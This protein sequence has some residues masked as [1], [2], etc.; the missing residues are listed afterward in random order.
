MIID[1]HCHAGKGDGLSGPWDTDAPLDNYLQW[2]RQSGINKS[3]IF[4][5]FH[6]NYAIANA[7]VAKIVHSNTERFYGFAFVHSQRD[8]GRIFEM[9]K[10]AVEDYGFKG[11][12]L[13]RADATIS[14]EVCE[15]AQMFGLPILYDPMG[16][17]AGM[18]SAV[19][20]YPQVNFIIPHLSSFADDW[21][22]QKGCI[23]LLERYPNAYADTS[24]VRR[25]D[26]LQEAIKRAGAKKFLFGSDGPWLHPG[27]ELSKI[28]A[29]NLSIKAR[30][31]ILSENL[32]NLMPKERAKPKSC[33]CKTCLNYEIDLTPNVQILSRTGKSNIFTQRSN[34]PKKKIPKPYLDH[35]IS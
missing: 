35:E 16:D 19:S 2:C 20:E 27:V 28:Y 31:M 9:V 29:L 10:T 7:E 23:T 18:E 17:I 11:I 15:V 34:V 13:H 30:R 22:A 25:F 33:S 26:V 14:R 4:A 21:K 5:A 12:K 8:A 1:C 32:L 6:S 3:V 24:G